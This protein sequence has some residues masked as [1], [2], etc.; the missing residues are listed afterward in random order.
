MREVYIVIRNALS[1]LLIA[2][3]ALQSVVVIADVHQSHQSGTQHLEFEHDHDSDFAGKKIQYEAEVN[4]SA[5]QYDCHHCC[6]C[7]AIAHLFLTA[8]HGIVDISSFGQELPEYSLTYI[9][10]LLL[11]AFR[12]PIV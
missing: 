7:H 4:S 11:P 3:I 2:L 9:S 1:Y 6:H 5:D 12:P 10:N 8:G